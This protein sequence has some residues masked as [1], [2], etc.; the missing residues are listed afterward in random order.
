MFI[1]NGPKINVSGL[2][3]IFHNDYASLTSGSFVTTV[4]YTNY[5]VQ[6]YGFLC[7]KSIPGNANGTWVELFP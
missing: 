6:R 7:S 5:T 4:T 3:K 1:T 2:N